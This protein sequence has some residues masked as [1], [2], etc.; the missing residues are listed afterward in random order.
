MR[1]VIN[2]LFS[3]SLIILTSFAGE[4]TPETINADTLQGLTSSAF[5][6]TNDFETLKLTIER[7]KSNAEA[8][9]D[10]IVDL[11]LGLSTL[12]NEE[13]LVREKDLSKILEEYANIN[14]ELIS[15]SSA[16]TP[17]DRENNIY[18]LQSD[19]EDLEAELLS[20]QT[21]V[22]TYLSH[23]RSENETWY[24]SSTGG[25]SGT[26][27]SLAASATAAQY[28]LLAGQSFR[29]KANSVIT[30]IK[31]KLPQGTQPT[32]D[33]VFIAPYNQ[34]LITNTFT[35]ATSISTN[36]AP[37]YTYFFPNFLA[38][39]L[40]PYLFGLRTTNNIPVSVYR[41]GNAYID[42]FGFL[43]YGSYNRYNANLGV[44][45]MTT[46]SQYDLCFDIGFR[47]GTNIVIGAEGIELK[48]NASLKIDGKRVATAQE[49]N[50]SIAETSQSIYHSLSNHVFSSSSIANGS[51]TTEKLANNAVTPDKISNGAI[52]T[53]KIADNAITETK[54]S[55]N[56]VT[57]AKIHDSAI[58]TDK[59]ANNAITAAKLSTNA[60]TTAKIQ[61]SAII[62]SKIA[63]SAITATKLSTNAV[64]TAKIQNSAITASKIADS[65]I[66]ESKLAT[67]A[68][69]ASKISDGAVQTSKISDDAITASKLS[70]NAVTT[71][72]INAN[73]VI[74]SKI[75]DG[76][77][78][79][80]KLSTGAVSA[81]TI[82]DGA[83]TTGKI[84]DS[85]VT[86]NK[87]SDNSVTTAK[88]NDNAI[89]NSKIANS[90][91][92]NTKIAENAI[93]GG[94]IQSNAISSYHILDQAIISEKV[95]T[96]SIQLFH[97]TEPLKSNI[98]LSSGGTVTGKLDV[99]ELEI[100][101]SGDWILG[102]TN[103]IGNLIIANSNA[104]ISSTGGD[105]RLQASS[106]KIEALNF[107]NLAEIQTGS[108]VV[109][110]DSQNYYI[111]VPDITEEAV[112]LLTPC[113][114]MN[115]DYWVEIDA[116]LGR[117]II[118]LGDK[119]QTS[120]KFNYCI[121]RK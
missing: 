29:T 65:A 119:Q 3:L 106:G 91:I 108:I 4:E 12:S 25:L 50:A 103:R 54:L 44:Y 87:L 68:V 116:A 92:T 72:K 23:I 79:E 67:G 41:S 80:S 30:S 57:T 16:D 24:F 46:E 61:S 53:A 86:E 2:I 89:V 94:K 83:V 60:V 120:C 5:I 105:L 88:I 95:A 7:L 35:Y 59:I 110:A 6:S 114:G 10:G 82:N 77:I 64:T 8:C 100:L 38:T 62:T 40:T 26:N 71:A 15:I 49:V 107:V 90:S 9:A 96:N 52:D 17:G 32:P 74:E 115:T 93:T 104:V 84:A 109:P 121:T 27:D 112:V 36:E 33:K 42:D 76:A 78:T 81:A 113:Q 21:Y 39:A 99:C 56:A 48:N 69:N 20:L 47:S 22:Q 85:A 73:A 11:Q 70:A 63:D 51:I 43:C 118:N 101:S 117:I 98:V 111:E 66:T 13:R 102:S 55:T 19:L 14:S 18:A 58:T 34:T 37:V 97:F 31:I 1:K 75:A 45:A 28:T